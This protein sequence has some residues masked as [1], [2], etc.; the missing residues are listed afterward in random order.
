MTLYQAPYY[1]SVLPLA[2]ISG[3]VPALRVCS[4]EFDY[5]CALLSIFDKI[6]NELFI[7]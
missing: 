4:F 6:N 5:V 2:I 7:I 3:T 1:E